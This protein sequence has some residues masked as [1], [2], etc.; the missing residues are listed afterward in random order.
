MLYLF[1]LEFACVRSVRCLDSVAM[2]WLSCCS[3]VLCCCC[4]LLLC[5]DCLLRVV[6]S[7]R[8]GIV[9]CVLF[10]LGSLGC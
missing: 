10:C 2:V 8:V 9:V 1:E 5:C 3:R 4:C 6:V 7:V